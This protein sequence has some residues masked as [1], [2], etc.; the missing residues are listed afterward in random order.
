MATV[1]KK[2]EKAVQVDCI[3]AYSSDRSDRSEKISAILDINVVNGNEP[4]E[5][6]KTENNAVNN[7]NTNKNT[8]T[9]NTNTNKNNTNVNNTNT[10]KNTNNTNSNNKANNVV[11]NTNTNKDGTV[12]GTK[13]PAAGAG[14]II[15]PIVVF[16]VLAY[17]SYKKYIK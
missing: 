15:A 5:E 9:N 8:N 3:V 2:V 14:F 10:N 6:N 17:I 12:A 7:T 4:T 11:N 16:A 1:M 13:I